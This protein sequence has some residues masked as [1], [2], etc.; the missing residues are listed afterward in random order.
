MNLLRGKVQKQSSG[1]VISNELS[2]CALSTR[3][4]ITNRNSGIR[5][6][7][8]QKNQTVPGE[9]AGDT[10]CTKQS[11]MIFFECGGKKESH[12]REQNA[13]VSGAI[14]ANP[15]NERQVGAKCDYRTK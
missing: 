5:A 11:Q 9:N 2:L 13:R 8:P 15:S 3:L 10:Q 6:P 4:H 7:F 12:N 1:L 14:R